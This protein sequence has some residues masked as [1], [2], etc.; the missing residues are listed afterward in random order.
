MTQQVYTTP[1][2]AE[3]T[4]I[5]E[6]TIR[7]WL[8]RHPEVFQM[9]VHLVMDEHGQKLWTEAGIE[10]LRSRRTASKNAAGNDAESDAP[11]DA[12]NLLESLLETDAQV[13][14]LEYW[15]QLPGRVLRR[16]KQMKEQPTPEE[17]EIVATSIRAALNVGTSHLLLPTYQPMLLEG[18]EDEQD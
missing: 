10:I 13:L 3:L 11:D 8:R 5:K 2:A 18:G 1:E 17:R 6:A 16:I 15:R 14:A 7:S 9:D 4:G 12:V